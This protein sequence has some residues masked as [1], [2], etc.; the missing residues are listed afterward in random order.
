MYQFTDLPLISFLK[1][2]SQFGRAD[3]IHFDRL[4]PALII[5]LALI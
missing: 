4:F 2:Y 3:K 5:T 1:P